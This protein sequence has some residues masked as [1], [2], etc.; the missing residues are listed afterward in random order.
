MKKLGYCAIIIL[1]VPTIPKIYVELKCEE[2]FLSEQYKI[3]TTLE[4]SITNGDFLQFCTE[5]N[6]PGYKI[7]LDT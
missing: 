6:Y 5:P 2:C 7:Y 1:A 4:H 3:I